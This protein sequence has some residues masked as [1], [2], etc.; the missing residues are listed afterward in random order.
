MKIKFKM[1]VKFILRLKTRN[2]VRDGLMVNMSVKVRVK[3]GS[4]KGQCQGI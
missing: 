2:T 4:M 1:T 3:G